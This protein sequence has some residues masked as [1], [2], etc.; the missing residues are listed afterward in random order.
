MSLDLGYIFFP[1]DIQYFIDFE[2][3]DNARQE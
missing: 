3:Q 1:T 2:R